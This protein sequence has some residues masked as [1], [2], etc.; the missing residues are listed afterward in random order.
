MVARLLVLDRG[1][2]VNAKTRNDGNALHLAVFACSASVGLEA[3]QLL[4]DL[5]N[6]IP[7]V[8]VDTN[9]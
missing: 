1:A 2:Y 9:D 7:L 5:E 3:I 8:V 4:L 6:W